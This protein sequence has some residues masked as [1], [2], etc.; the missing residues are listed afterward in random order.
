M[1]RGAKVRSIDAVGTFSAA[2]KNFE[3]E[4]S[5]AL[6]SLDMEVRRAL[7]WIHQERKEYWK[8]QVRRRQDKVAEA[9]GDLERCMTYRSTDEQ[10]SCHE[11]KIALEKAKRRLRVAEEKVRI[12]RHWARVL[13]HEVH[14]FRGSMNQLAHWL[15]VDHPQSVAA[16]E[17]MMSALS[18]YVGLESS[19]QSVADGGPMSRASEPADATSG[20]SERDEDREDGSPTTDD[21]SDEPDDRRRSSDDEKESSR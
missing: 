20:E 15:Q 3:E 13:D 10:P 9:R 21:P 11:E 12:V 4:A 19:V 2:L 8:Q 1:A 14:E 16:L 6:T 17:R 5:G 18:A 7:E